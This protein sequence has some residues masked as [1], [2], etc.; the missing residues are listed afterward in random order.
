MLSHRDALFTLRELILQS[1]IRSVE[2]L[3]VLYHTETGAKR[4]YLIAQRAEDSDNKHVLCVSLYSG[5]RKKTKMTQSIVVDDFGEGINVIMSLVKSDL[6]K[7]HIDGMDNPS[8]FNGYNAR[9]HKRL[10]MFSPNDYQMI[11]Y[12]AAKDGMRTTTGLY[13]TFKRWKHYFYASLQVREQKSIDKFIYSSNTLLDF[14]HVKAMGK[15]T[16]IPK[17]LERYQ[18][19]H[20]PYDIE[21]DK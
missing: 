6:W 4:S 3:I 1:L 8:Y 12:D 5:G 17:I 16:T 19:E 11:F 15:L 2:N 18:E 21:T 10:F 13:T 9:Y 14:F 7:I 20:D